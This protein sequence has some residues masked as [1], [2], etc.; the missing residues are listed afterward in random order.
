[1][2]CPLGA[3]EDTAGDGAVELKGEEV[4]GMPGLDRTGPMG[5]GPMT[6]GG[7]GR[8]NPRSRA[9]GLGSFGS[10]RGGRG[11][12]R[13]RGYGRGFG[14]RGARFDDQGW[15]GPA[16]GSYPGPYAVTGEDEISMLK[17]EAEMMKEELNAV[18]KRIE[19]LGSEPLKTT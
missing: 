1:M 4:R 2:K 13:G 15:Y 14:R 6:G 8:C 17:K 16:Y 3:E 19:E 5:A 9:Y 7:F 11:F 12:G 18:N 10:G